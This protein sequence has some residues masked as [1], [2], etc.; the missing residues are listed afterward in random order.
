MWEE[1]TTNA[2]IRTYFGFIVVQTMNF[3]VMNDMS[4]SFKEET[5]TL[6]HQPEVM[7]VQREFPSS[8]LLSNYYYS[9]RVCLFFTHSHSNQQLSIIGYNHEESR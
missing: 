6:P 3:P 7:H 8:Q 1:K 9:G 2:R 5:I 4:R